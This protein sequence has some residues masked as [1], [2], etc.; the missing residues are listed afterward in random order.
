MQ[1]IRLYTQMNLRRLLFVVLIALGMNITMSGRNIPAGYYSSIDGKST[2]TLKTALHL[3]INPHTEISSYSNLPRYF[4]YTDVYPDSRRWWDMYSDIPRYAPSFSGLNR[5]HSFPKSWWGGDTDIPAYIDLN[6]LYPSD[7]HANSAKSNYPLGIVDKTKTPK[8]DNGVTLVGTPV[9]GQGGG[10]AYVFEPADEYKGDFARTYFYMVTCYQN[11]SFT[12]LYMLIN[13]SYPTLNSWS[14]D[15]LLKWHKQDPVSQKEIDRNEEI[16]GYQN[17]RNPF[18]DF[19]ELANYIWG[20]K[21][22]EAFILSEHINGYVPVGD[23]TLIN[24][25][26]GTNLDFGEVAMGTSSSAKL[27]VHGENLKENSN[28]RLTIYDNSETTD[29]EYFSMDG[30]KQTSVSASAANSPEGVWIT[31]QYEPTTLGS[32]S[33]RLV[34]SGGGITGSVGIGLRGECLPMPKLSAPTAT[35]ATNIT[36]TSYVANWTPAE[37]EEVDYYIVNR[38]RYSNGGATTEQLP[39]EDTYL[40]IEDFS[41]SESYTVQSVRLGIYSPESNSITVSPASITGVESI[42]AFGYNAYPGGIIITCSETLQNVRIFEPTGRCVRTIHEVRNND[43]IELP[44]GIYIITA[45]GTN[46]PIKVN[47]RNE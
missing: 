25:T 31:I 16:W 24:P 28:L 33:T 40:Q 43:I 15:L 36:T 29:S 11:L 8:F 13:G 7:M 41:G 37:G 27:L 30:G 18:I 19:P 22:G 6:H 5:E 44:N 1:N 35:A 2:S 45:N 47:V 32:H 3:I 23:P 10:C 21:M 46:K 26:Q 34:V 14:R 42:P 20:D 9:T 17:N 4:E 39:A 38:T 12:T